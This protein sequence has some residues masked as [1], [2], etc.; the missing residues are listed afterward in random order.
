MGSQG[1]H[2]SGNGQRGAGGREK[3]ENLILSQEKLAF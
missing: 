2:R 1:C 3:S